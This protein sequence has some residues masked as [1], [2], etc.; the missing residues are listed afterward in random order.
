MINPWHISGSKLERWSHT[1]PDHSCTY[2][3]S[4]APMDHQ[5]SGLSTT[6]KLKAKPANFSH[7][8]E[9]HKRLDIMAGFKSSKSCVNRLG[10]GSV[11]HQTQFRSNK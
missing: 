9:S 2:E 3:Q 4:Q 5:G 8:L 6:N 11:G 10:N 7:V 1:W